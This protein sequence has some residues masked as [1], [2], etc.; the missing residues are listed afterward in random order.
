MVY[1]MTKCK[2]FAT[3]A[4]A[5]AE[6]SVKNI[7]YGVPIYID[8]ST[9]GVITET[10]TTSVAEPIEMVDGRWAV[11]FNDESYTDTIT[12]EQVKVV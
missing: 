4:E 8:S 1:F 10:V 11:A 9:G 12:P 2:I 6:I 7:D 5:E 3:K